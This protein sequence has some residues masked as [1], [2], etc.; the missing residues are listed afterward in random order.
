MMKLQNGTLHVGTKKGKI[1][2]GYPSREEKGQDF[3]K[4]PCEN[5]GGL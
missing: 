1:V 4:Y 3:E 2:G 5:Q